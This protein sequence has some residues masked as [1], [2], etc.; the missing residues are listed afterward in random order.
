MT[1]FVTSLAA[2]QLVEQGK[3]SVD[4]PDVIKQHLPE[5]W[6]QQILT[7]WSDDG[8]PQ[9]V[10]RTKPITL[11]HLLT[12]TSG[13]GYAFLQPTIEKYE[14]KHGL[15]GFLEPGVGV[16]AYVRPLLFEPGTK[17]AYGTS[18]DW[19]GILVMRV[20]G[21]TLEDYFHE[22]IFGPLGITRDEIT[23][24]PTDS[25][26]ARLQ[27]M[28]AR[29]A[30]TKDQIILHPGWRNVA[31]MTPDMV[32]M[33]T[34][35]A[36]LLGTLR[37]YLR[38]L[39]GVLRC[40]QPGGIVSPETFALVFSDQMPEGDG[41]KDLA[42]FLRFMGVRDK[43]Q[44]EDGKVTHS[45]GLCYMP[46]GSEDG[47]PPGSA[48]WSGESSRGCLHP[49]SATASSVPTLTKQASRRPSSS[50]ARRRAS[51]PSAGPTSWRRTRIACTTS[52]PSS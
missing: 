27:S 50:S 10:D 37:A 42:A 21:Q 29:A 14:Q 12:H 45:L 13:L 43:L 2:L 34:G 22:H 26:K 5:L 19:A 49:S 39:A 35:G 16:E 7:G 11:R 23:F 6:E 28:C 30:A 20:T 48:R 17:Y 15:K 38:F 40:Q 1:K 32:G 51:P 52:C 47:P 41:K 31:K 3:I 9:L 46:F 18:V 4:D 8:E 24:L 36:G 25:V 33:Q 44:T